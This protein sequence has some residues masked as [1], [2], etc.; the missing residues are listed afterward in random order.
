MGKLLDYVLGGPT[1]PMA[2]DGLVYSSSTAKSSSKAPVKS[3]IVETT[4]HC[5]S[6]TSG[7]FPSPRSSSILSNAPHQREQSSPQPAESITRYARHRHAPND[8]HRPDDSSTY[9]TN[10]RESVESSSNSADTF[11]TALEIPADGQALQAPKEVAWQEHDIPEELGLVKDGVPT[12]IRNIVQES[13]DE[14]QAIRASLLQAQPFLGR[15][16]VEGLGISSADSDPTPAE[17]SAMASARRS[18][19]TTSSTSNPNAPTEPDSTSQAAPASEY[20]PEPPITINDQLL[21]THAHQDMLPTFSLQSH[22]TD[23]EQRFIN[24]KSQTKRTHRIFRILHGGKSKGD[25]TPE[26]PKVEPAMSECTS[27]FDDIPDTDAVA[28]PCTHKYCL[29]CFSQLVTTAIEHEINFPP[30]CCLSDVP[31]KTI[32][33]NLPPVTKALFDQ[34]ALEYAVPVSNR[35]YCVSSTCGKWI[36]TRHAKRANG[37]ITCPHCR[38]KLCTLCRGPQHAANQDCPQDFGLDQ[39]LEQAERAGWRRCY[40][41][42]A[43]VELNTGCR[44]ITC[45]CRAQFW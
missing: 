17:S 39:T 18:Q 41:C 38:T 43:I 15:A 7:T 30:K 21:S 20:H 32:R 8:V 34:K 25:V 3:L 19:V 13:L 9:M 22:I 12:E 27:C 10:R 45:K 24:S 6:P 33:D 16:Q 44:H 11:R 1:S 5:G 35:Y 31:N 2:G 42:R 14:H 36:D 29:P 37:A 26:S 28:L 4:G 40:N 23:M